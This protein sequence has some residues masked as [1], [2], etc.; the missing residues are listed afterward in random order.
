MVEIQRAG[1]LNPTPIQSQA[2]PVC[3]SGRDMIGVAATGSG[4]TLAF[5][6]PAVVHINAQP[7]LQRGDGPIALVLAPTRELACQIEKE[8]TK[9]GRSSSIKNT[10]V[11]GGAPKGP[12]RG[13]LRRGV[14]I[15]IATPG[16]LIDFLEQRATNLRRVTYLVL[17]EADRMLDM[18]FEPQLR[19]IVGQIR[20][21]RQTVM[22]SATWPREVE[23]LARDFLKQPVQVNIGS[24]DLS[25]NTDITQIVEM[26]SRYDK[27]S[28]VF[29]LLNSIDP[30]AKVLIFANTKRM[31][32]DLTRD[33]RSSGI[34]ALGL[35]GGK[36][37]AEREF[38]LGSFKSGEAPIMIG[39]DVVGR[40]IDVDNIAVV[41]N[42]D[43]PTN[44][45]DYIH[46]IGRTGRA[47]NK[48]TAY[49]F[50][51]PDND[52]KAARPLL[53]ILEDAE[54][55]IPPALRDVAASSRGRGGGGRRRGGYRRGGGGRRNAGRTGSNSLPLG[56]GGGRY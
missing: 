16:R 35:H 48:G 6:F 13:A 10:C 31:V 37:Q 39:T 26:V 17:D 50:F 54:Q 28:R 30:T 14:E 9:F 42:Y 11:Y 52:S 27:K 19:K 24:T 7:L 20:P 15:V 23:S 8:C 32:D 43:L 12:Q 55:E 46:R 44:I 3:M 1:F 45:E 4:K 47:G 29:Q 49:A 33:M 41:I 36:E 22:F 18:G 56:G 25:A 40:G 2:W 51:D 21:E 5:L 38:V 34:R 53:K